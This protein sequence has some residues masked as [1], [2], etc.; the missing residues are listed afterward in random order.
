[1]ETRP[2]NGTLFVDAFN[3]TGN[4]GEYTFAN[5]VYLNQADTTGNGAYDIVAG[6]VLY[7]PSTDFNTSV[8]LT[9]VVHRY[10]LTDVTVV[11]VATISGTMVWDETGAEGLQ[12][13]TNGVYSGISATS[14]NYKYGFAPS[15]AIYSDLPQGFAVQTVQTDLNNITD[16]Q[17]G[18]GP[19]PGPSDAYKTTIGN[20]SAKTFV[21]QHDLN[22]FDVDIKVFDITTGGDVY[23]GIVRT[24]PNAIQ[25]DFT[26]PIEPNS[27]RVIVKPL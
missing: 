18:G 26:Y 15:E 21:I 16:N 2:I 24:G 27:H 3:P 23:P 10:R 8:Q 1:M 25:L 9:G 5:A 4:P 13:P 20:S 7:V 11:D 19:G 12:V 17:S 14:P 6:F 22:T